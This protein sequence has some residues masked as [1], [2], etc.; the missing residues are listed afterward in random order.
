MGLFLLYK[1]S[2][3]VKFIYL[4]Q[5]K[6]RDHSIL[7][8]RATVEGGIFTSQK[9]NGGGPNKPFSAKKESA[10]KKTRHQTTRRTHIE[11]GCYAYKGKK[12]KKTFLFMFM[13]GCVCVRHF[14]SVFFY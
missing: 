11:P 13:E 10:P 5:R 2:K 8:V 14:F 1:L 7:A 9:R 12:T 3:Q 6:T 4:K